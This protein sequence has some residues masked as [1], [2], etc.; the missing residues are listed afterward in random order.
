MGELEIVPTVSGQGQ[1]K[2]SCELGTEPLDSI[3]YGD[4][5]DFL[6]AC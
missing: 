5:I 6:R 4:F 3:K 1:V 2:G